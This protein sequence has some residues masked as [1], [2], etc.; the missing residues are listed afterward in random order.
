M[1]LLWYE[2][3]LCLLMLVLG[4]WGLDADATQLPLHADHAFWLC[5]PNMQCDDDF[6]GM[7]IMQSDSHCYWVM[8]GT[9]CLLKWLLWRPH[10]GAELF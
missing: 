2:M 3:L 7:L 10:G 9:V 6:G 4:P 8:D 1:Y 5:V